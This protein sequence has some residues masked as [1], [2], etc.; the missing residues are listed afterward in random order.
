MMFLTVSSISSV[1]IFRAEMSGMA[2]S[3]IIFLSWLGGKGV[4]KSLF[5]TLKILGPK[6]FKIYPKKHLKIVLNKL[7]SVFSLSTQFPNFLSVNCPYLGGST[8]S[9]ISILFIIS[10]P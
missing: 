7:G 5:L 6:N 3:E 8:L 10:L 4:G 1:A 9:K 2:F